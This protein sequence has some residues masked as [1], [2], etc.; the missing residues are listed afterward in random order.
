MRRIRATVL[1][2]IC[3]YC[4]DMACSGMRCI[5]LSQYLYSGDLKFFGKDR[6]GGIYEDQ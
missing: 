5:G 2:K 3:E 1:Q 6:I 4:E